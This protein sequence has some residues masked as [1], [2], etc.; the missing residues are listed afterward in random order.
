MHIIIYAK[1][2]MEK[3]NFCLLVL[4]AIST[5]LCGSQYV[6]DHDNHPDD[7]SFLEV[8]IDRGENAWLCVCFF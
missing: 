7:L 3:M 4:L 5:T 2:R 1:L 6:P 8:A